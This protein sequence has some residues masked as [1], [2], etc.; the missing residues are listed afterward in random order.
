MARKTKFNSLDRQMYRLGR[1][2]ERERLFPEFSAELSPTVLRARGL[3]DEEI[4]HVLECPVGDVEK[5]IEFDRH[6]AAVSA[7][8]DKTLVKELAS[9]DKALAEMEVQLS[10]LETGMKPLSRK[11]K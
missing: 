6:T 4:A 1:Q 5:V 11:K 9:V 10:I 8:S 2:I 3:S 7:G